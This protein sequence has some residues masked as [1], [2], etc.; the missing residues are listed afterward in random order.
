MNNYNLPKIC[1]VVLLSVFTLAFTNIGDNR[2]SFESK[3]I[4][5]FA[6]L[7]ESFQ[8]S[9]PYGLLCYPYL[10]VCL[11]VVVDDQKI[12]VWGLRIPIPTISE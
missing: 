3:E 12:Q 5:E 8:K 4:I 9:D 2:N 11:D 7:Q 10:R 6:K 1:I